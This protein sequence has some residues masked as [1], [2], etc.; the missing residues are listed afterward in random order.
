MARACREERPESPPLA[1][2]SQVHA[3]GFGRGGLSELS[4]ALEA[5][6]AELA[7]KLDE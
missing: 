7:A 6:R 3:F 4:K 2:T 1:L 5:T